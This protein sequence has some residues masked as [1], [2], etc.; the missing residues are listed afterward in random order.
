[1]VGRP[2]VGKSSFLNALLKD[3]RLVVDDL[4]GT[5]RDPIDIQ[6]KKGE[7]TYT[8]V[9]TAGIRRFSQIK[10]TVLFQSVRTTREMIQ[11]SDVCLVLAD[12]S[13]GLQRDDLQI[14]RWVIEEG[15]GALLLMNKWD[16]VKEGIQEDAEKLIRQRLGNLNIVPILFTSAVTGRNVVKA[17]DVAAE[18]AARHSTHFETHRL[19]TF[20]Q[21]IRKARGIFPGGQIPR[22][23]YLVQTH[24]CPPRFLLFG[25]IE[26]EIFTS[27]TRFLERKMRENFPL[28]G[29]PVQFELREERK[30]K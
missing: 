29:T 18:V 22:I 27:F 6:F 16:I 13:K 23:T 30:K 9:D 2:N 1:V 11:R 25:S 17:V 4:P 5:T 7:T 14:L 20:L 12:G 3:D 28:L 19:N 21:G 8:L 15:R 26:R 10:E 24:S